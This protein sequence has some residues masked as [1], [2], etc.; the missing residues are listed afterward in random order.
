MGDTF[1]LGCP[2]EIQD[3][4]QFPKNWITIKIRKSHCTN[5]LIFVAISKIILSRKISHV[6]S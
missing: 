1:N 3:N 6:L 5:L 2:P 4:K